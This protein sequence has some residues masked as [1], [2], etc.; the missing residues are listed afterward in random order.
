MAVA[1]LRKTISKVK[2]DRI[3]EITTLSAR[4]NEYGDPKILSCYDVE[5]SQIFI[6]LGMYKEVTNK[7]PWTRDYYPSTDVE[8][9]GK[10]LTKETDL[11]KH[12]R[13]QV[14]VSEQLK[15]LLK[16]QHCAF[17]A[18]FTGFGKCWDP[19]QRIMLINHTSKPVKDIVVHD[20]LMGDDLQPRHV[21]SISRG[22]GEMFLITAFAVDG[23]NKVYETPIMKVNAEHILCLTT[24]ETS[25]F[26]EVIEMEV[27]EYLSLS[28]E[29][30]KGMKLYQIATAK[31]VASV[32]PYPRLKTEAQKGKILTYHETSSWGYFDLQIYLINLFSEF[33]SEDGK[34]KISTLK[35]SNPEMCQE[36]ILNELLI[37]SSRL[38]VLLVK[39]FNVETNELEVFL[40]TRSV[41][42]F[43]ITPQGH[44]P[45][46]GFTVAGSNRRFLLDSGI[47]THNTTIGC[48]LAAFSKMKTAI[49]CFLDTVREQWVQALR[50]RT[51]GKVQDVRG[52]KLDPDA[53]FYVMGLLS[54]KNFSRASLEGIGFLILD[55]AHQVAAQA[56]EKA[57]L[58]FQPFWIQ[59]FS[60]T[61]RRSDGLHNYLPLYFGPRENFIV[62]REKKQF[63]V[64]KIETNFKP[65]IR[66]IRIKGVVRPNWTL[67]LNSIAENTE[68]HV[69][70]ANRV[71]DILQDPEEYHLIMTNRI[72]EG[73]AIANLL[74]QAY[75]DGLWSC[76]EEDEPVMKIF[77]ARKGI[78]KGISA[79]TKTG[80]VVDCK[81][82]PPEAGKYRVQVA[83]I[84]KAGVGYDDPT[85]TSLS[86]I[87]DLTDVEQLEGRIRKEGATIEDYVDDH[88]S[89]E[90]HYNKRRAHYKRKGATIEVVES[91]L[92]RSCNS[93][94]PLETYGLGSKY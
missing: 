17:F 76:G 58:K 48:E 11:E 43:A 74:R 6:P 28:E 66:N 39:S 86:I 87:S 80:E 73:D 77:G 34:I 14:A 23:K 22:E 78:S 1:F 27:R 42:P 8:F 90:T 84:K 35:T 91:P 85:R 10:L 32:V 61:P 52:K 79:I 29:L 59:G 92:P 88:K 5:G 16:T 69:F 15:Q 60:A 67:A 2:F 51:N 4:K 33:A 72:E 71:I 21:T 24:S 47:V 13:D 57:L 9:T 50:T 49:V 45:Y 44:G 64:R 25:H 62:R 30:R 89:F 56:A 54:C 40:D 65:T 31:K 38:G 81:K 93:E 7:F 82:V 68:R 19:E 75:E 20:L 12:S 70:V 37:I 53:D 18:G 63:L 94:N 55:E 83:G 46:A 3:E 41:Y 36:Q 26:S